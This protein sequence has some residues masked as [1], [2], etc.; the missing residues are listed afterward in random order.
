MT[1]AKVEE[2]L[3]ELSQV[4]VQKQNALSGIALDIQRRYLEVQETQQKTEAAQTARRAVRALLATTLANFGLGLGEGKEVF[5]NL[6]L[7]ARIVS[8]YYTIVRDFNIAAAKLT[9]ATGQE[10]TT[11]SY[12][13]Y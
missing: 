8:E 3:A 7:Y 5:E 9:Q 2:R 1:H 12:R 11:L 4:E 13:Q 10:V 6:G